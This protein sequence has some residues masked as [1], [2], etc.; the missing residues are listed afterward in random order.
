MV[1]RK[2][3]VKAKSAP[4]ISP[5][6]QF[7]QDF[8]KGLAPG[9]KFDNRRAA[10]AWKHRN[11][12]DTKEV[13]SPRVV[14]DS[15]PSIMVSSQG[16]ATVVSRPAE[17]SPTV[18]PTSGGGPSVAVVQ[19]VPVGQSNDEMYGA[20]ADAVHQTGANLCNVL[21]NERVSIGREHLDRLNKCLVVLFRKYDKDGKVLEH[22]PEVA[23]ILTLAD[24]GTQVYAD[25]KRQKDKEKRETQRQSD[26]ATASATVTGSVVQLPPARSGL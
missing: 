22:A 20:L 23:Y 17:P 21:T 7:V 2:K 19:S 13:L 5:Y 6:N 26:G 9:E 14:R 25:I 10:E 18:A 3:T 24:I 16:E 8:K 1:K 11:E 4:T 12:N 15:A